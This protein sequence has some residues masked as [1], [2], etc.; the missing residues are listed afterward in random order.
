[1]SLFLRRRSERP[2]RRAWVRARS[3][4]SVLETVVALTL[5][6]TTAIGIAGLSLTVAKRG[7]GNDLVTK[8]TALLQ[9]QMNWLQ[10]IP[11]DSL[12][13][14]AGAVIVSTGP[15]PHRRAVSITRTGSL[16]RV[17]VQVTPLRALDK[18]E[19]ITFDR[20]RPTTSP[21]CTGC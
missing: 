12:P 15:F 20:A 6:G 5:F 16:T 7:A 8:R 4:V 2:L 1:M 14:K 19:T 18:S 3:G 10:A 9:Q 21:L 17:K 13:A 11:Y